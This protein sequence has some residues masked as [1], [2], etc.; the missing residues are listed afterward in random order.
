MKKTSRKNKLLQE[1]LEILSFDLALI[2]TGWCKLVFDQST[3]E[4]TIESCGCIDTL[5]EEGR[6]SYTDEER[7]KVLATKLQEVIESHTFDYVV[8]EAQFYNRERKGISKKMQKAKR[9]FNEVLAVNKLKLDGDYNPSTWKKHVIGNYAA[10]KKEVAVKIK[11]QFGFE[12]S[13]QDITD[14]VAIAVCF[15]I[16]NGY[17]S[18]EGATK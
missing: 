5:L 13:S 4:I 8:K 14:A 9:T 3:G 11:E 10:G 2:Y 17:I 16:I 15:L 7:Q 1:K 12:F 18:K 6:S